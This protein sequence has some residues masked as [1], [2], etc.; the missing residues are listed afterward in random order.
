[1]THRLRRQAGHHEA[2]RTTTSWP[3]GTRCGGVGVWLPLRCHGSSASNPST[4]GLPARLS[5]KPRASGT[6]CRR[7]VGARAKAEKNGC[8]ARGSNLSELVCLLYVSNVLCTWFKPLAFLRLYVSL[9]AYPSGGSTHRPASFST[10]EVQP[11][12]SGVSVDCRFENVG[13]VRAS[14]GS[15][16]RPSSTKRRQFSARLSSGAS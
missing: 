16:L 9:Y 7:Y 1:M 11:R 13:P 8:H 6:D 12:D 14:G 15:F 3:R 5:A 10:D 2:S 4:D